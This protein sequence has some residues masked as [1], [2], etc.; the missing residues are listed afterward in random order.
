MTNRWMTGARRHSFGAPAPA[1]RSPLRWDVVA[2][3]DWTAWSAVVAIDRATARPACVAAPSVLPLASLAALSTLW[4]TPLEHL[5]FSRALD[6]SLNNCL[7]S[8]SSSSSS[9]S[10]RAISCS[11][12]RDNV[13]FRMSVVEFFLRFVLLGFAP[14]AC[15]GRTRDACTARPTSHGVLERNGRMGIAQNVR[16]RLRHQR[17]AHLAVRHLVKRDC[18]RLV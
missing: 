17:K 6:S 9:L 3:I 14:H 13:V 10:N 5:E 18:D 2:A 4:P 8:S 15:E 7:D 11:C 12:C 16:A 1:A